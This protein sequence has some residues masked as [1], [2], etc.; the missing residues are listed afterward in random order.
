MPGPLPKPT[1]LRLVESGGR[2]RGRFKTR[3]AQEPR[4]QSPIG[5]P[6]RH[7]SADEL[8]VWFR[9]LE[10]APEGLLTGL[11]RD[12]F[13]GFVVMAAARA[14]LWR[15]YHDEGS[16]ILI[17]AADD[18]KRWILASSLKHYKALTESLRVLSHELGF[19]PAARTRVAIIPP[20]KPADPLAEFLGGGAR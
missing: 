16:V 15:E 19:S 3:A 18:E 4:P 12:L 8:E 10:A 17:K 7:L 6:P 13:E 1:V 5:D 2:M 20:D 14:Q 9:L 11:D